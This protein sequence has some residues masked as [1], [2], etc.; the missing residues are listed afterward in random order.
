M[1]ANTTGIGLSVAVWLADDDYDH[2]DD[3]KAISATSIIKPIKQLILPN[4]ITTSHTKP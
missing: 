1:Y 4:E 2:D 3:P